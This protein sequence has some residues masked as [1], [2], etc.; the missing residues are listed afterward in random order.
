MSAAMIGFWA[1]GV[2]LPPDMTVLWPLGCQQR[3][4]DGV[5]PCYRRISIGM[6]DAGPPPATDTRRHDRGLTEVLLE[7]VTAA[8]D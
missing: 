5:P 2:G 1:A 7:H 3:S 8:A 6:L 4:R